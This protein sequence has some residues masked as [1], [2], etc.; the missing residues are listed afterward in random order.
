MGSG[1][2]D[3]DLQLPPEAFLVR[4]GHSD[5]PTLKRSCLQCVQV[6][7]QPGL[8]AF[9]GAGFSIPEIMAIEQNLAERNTYRATTAGALYSCGFEIEKTRG[10]LHYTIWLPNDDEALERF[11]QAFGPITANPL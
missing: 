8:S 10:P 2:G 11:E 7:G 6:Y 4:G 3:G 1:P 9:G 5:L